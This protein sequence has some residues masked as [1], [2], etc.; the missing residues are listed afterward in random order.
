MA[1]KVSEEDLRKALT[2]EQTPSEKADPKKRW[3][4]RMMRSAKQYHKICPYFD[5]KTGNCF[6][7][8]LSGYKKARCEREGKF[9]G[10]PVFIEYLENTYDKI[11]K[12]GRML[13][14]DFRDLP[15][16]I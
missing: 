14:M 12:E 15:M 10:C 6:I 3:V 16:F 5:K 8:L 13:P 9:D 4:D 11:T 1:A 2:V 7:K